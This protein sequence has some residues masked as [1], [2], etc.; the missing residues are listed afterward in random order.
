MRKS[1]EGKNKL[2]YCKGKEAAG[3]RW[4]LTVQ[5]VVATVWS[6]SSGKQ[7]G[8]VSS[9]K[10]GEGIPPHGMGRACSLGLINQIL[11]PESYTSP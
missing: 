7:E 9:K 1:R 2:T 3:S 5:K 4:N 10:A 6:R 11:L 8:A